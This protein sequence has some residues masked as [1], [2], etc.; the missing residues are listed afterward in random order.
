MRITLIFDV[1]STGLM[2]NLW[3]TGAASVRRVDHARSAYLAGMTSITTLPT[4]W[5]DSA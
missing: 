4:F 2:S 3:G 1:T 5:P